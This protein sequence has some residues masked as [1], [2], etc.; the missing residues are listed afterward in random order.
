MRLL[1]VVAAASLM[2]SSAVLAPMSA[3][4]S[5]NP[6]PPDKPALSAQDRAFNS[7]LQSVRRDARAAGV[8]DRVLRQALDGLTLNP[9]VVELDNRQP[10]RSS[11]AT[12]DRYLEQRLTRTR[13]GKGRQMMRR[14][15][16][17]LKRAERATGV[18]ARVIAALWGM[19]TNYGGYTGNYS[20][21]RSLA[22][23]AHDGRR[24]E[25]FRK[26]LIEAL[27]IVEQGHIDVAAMQGSWAG[28]MGHCQFM[29]TSFSRWA[30]DGNG[31]GKRDI[32]GTLP[33]V[34]HSTGNYLKRNGWQAGERWGRMVK[35]PL[36]YV[37]RVG[38]KKTVSEWKRLGFRLEDGRPLPSGDIEAQ[39]I[40]PDGQTGRAILAYPNYFVF[41]RWNKSHFFATSVGLLADELI[42]SASQ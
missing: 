24:G 3:H 15:A 36:G 25:F 37:H 33:D 8:S 9:R 29:P 35:L 38:V 11:R 5:G 21:I 28:A 30:L 22:T 14:H 39:L 4:A 40:M 19:E 26:E 1:T 23:L 18:P 16:A 42:V 32:W 41:R 10:E 34:F 13:I 7:F 27:K 12:L 6:T 20:V 2:I 17:E 31:D